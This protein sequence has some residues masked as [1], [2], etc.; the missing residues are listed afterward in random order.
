MYSDLGNLGNVPSTMWCNLED[1]LVRVNMIFW[2]SFSCIFRR[3]SVLRENFRADKLKFLR[4]DIPL[5]ALTATATAV[6]REDILSSLC[7]SNETKIVLTSFFRPN[8]RFSVSCLSLGWLILLPKSFAMCTHWSWFV[9]IQLVCFVLI[10]SW[11][12]QLF[13]SE[14][15]RFWALVISV[16]V[17]LCKFVFYFFLM[18]HLLHLCGICA[19]VY[20]FMH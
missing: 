5:M 12:W 4:F 9:C 6:V 18:Y 19:H 2:Q 3:L 8:L 17:I 10:T 13:V 16:P 14:F 7:M 20:L 1:L 11:K 15:F